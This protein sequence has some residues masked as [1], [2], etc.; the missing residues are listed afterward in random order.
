MMMIR[1]H[2]M[3][4]P[5]GLRDTIEELPRWVSPVPH[6]SRDVTRTRELGGQRFRARRRH[7]AALARRQL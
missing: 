1:T 2:L 7:S 6:H 3:A 4:H 5:D